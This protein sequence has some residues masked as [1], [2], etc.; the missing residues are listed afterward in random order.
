MLYFSVL[1]SLAKT[2]VKEFNEGEKACIE[3]AVM[4]MA[5]EQNEKALEAAIH[6]YKDQMRNIPDSKTDCSLQANLDYHLSAIKTS[7]AVFREKSV[8][9]EDQNAHNLLVVSR[10]GYFSHSSE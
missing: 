6:S 5:L 2:Y 4:V 3:T 8:Y 9:A 1:A 7:A 10:P